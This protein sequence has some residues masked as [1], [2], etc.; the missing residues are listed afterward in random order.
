MTWPGYAQIL[1]YLLV[2]VA[3]VKPLGGYMARV[4]EGEPIFLERLF[5]PIER[6]IYRLTGVSDDP[7]KRE[8]PWTTY[9][10]AML[11]FHV[12][13]LFVV[14]VILRL[15]DHLP[16][17]PQGMSAMTPDL[18]WN[19]AISFVTNTN[20]QS[21]GGESTLELLRADARACGAELRLRGGGHGDPRRARPRHLAQ[22]GDRHRQLLGRY[23][24]H[25][26]LHP[27]AALVR[28]RALPGLA[29]RRA[30]VQRVPHGVAPPGDEG[31]GRQEHR[32]SDHR[33][34]PGRLADRDQGPGHERRRLLQRELR[35]P[36]REPD[37]A[38]ELR[39]HPV[40]PRHPRGAHLHVRQDGQGHAAGLG[41]PRRDVRG[42]PAAPLAVRVARAGGEPDPRVAPHR[43]GRRR[44][45]RGRQHGRQ[46]G[47]LRHLGV[48]ALR[49]R[50][51]G[52]LERR[53]QR[54]ARLL[55]A[56]R[57]PRAAV[58]HPARRDHLR[59][60]R[61]RACTAC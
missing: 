27:A 31:R 8:M 43:P 59:R 32:R 50:H 29:G 21:Y 28:V 51:H 22:A 17:N 15:Q 61:V 16:L 23:D 2:L 6:L 19:T 60:R 11:L 57:R 33:R 26:A 18:S 7:E 34:G 46:G 10:G 35:A 5:R 41:P 55:L 30:D 24:P 49:R 45:A 25:D 38:L 9:A 20:W 37:S 42:L 44:A 47:A 54:D 3:L 40:A 39:H 14:Y 56:A 58:A 36:L 48:G 52:R 53:R 1:L 13:S 4:Y 12:V